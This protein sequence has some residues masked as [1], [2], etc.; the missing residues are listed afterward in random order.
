MGVI[1][2]QAVTNR[3]PQ[4]GG[5]QTSEAPGVVFDPTTGARAWK[6]L[7]P[8]D[9]PQSTSRRSPP[10]FQKRLANKQMFTKH[11]KHYHQ[12]IR[13]TSQNQVWPNSL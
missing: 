3:F 2:F 4:I 11:V 5:N 10:F 1:S 6:P 12:W 13:T 7:P 9:L 8:N